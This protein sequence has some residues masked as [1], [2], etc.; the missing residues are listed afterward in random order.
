MLIRIFATIF[1]L[2]S[3]TVGYSKTDIS[4][5]PREVLVEFNQ[6]IY[7][8]KYQTVVDNAIKYTEEN[9]PNMKKKHIRVRVFI[10]QEV[11]TSKYSRYNKHL[12]DIK[13][14]FQNETSVDFGTLANEIE[15][16]TLHELGHCSLDTMNI[17]NNTINWNI[18]LTDAEKQLYERLAK[19]DQDKIIIKNCEPNCNGGGLRYN[20]HTAY[21]EMFADL[22][23]AN[24][25]FKKNNEDMLLFLIELRNNLYFKNG[26]SSNYFSHKVISEF[27]AKDNFPVLTYE[28][29]IKTSQ[30]AVIDE[31]KNTLLHSQ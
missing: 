7:K 16:I 28:E 8:E 12:C 18:K 15:I 1:F 25:Y 20:I 11:G 19:E 5:I 30:R 4:K 26:K 22:F 23:S 24:Y 3:S 21:G 2:L 27:V 29:I 6:P 9:T 10:G 31:A 13:L 17:P 14:A